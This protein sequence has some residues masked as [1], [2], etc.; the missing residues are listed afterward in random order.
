MTS[1][2]TKNL[3][4]I[5]KPNYIFLLKTICCLERIL[6]RQC[7]VMY[8]T[9]QVAHPMQYKCSMLH[10]CII[11]NV[12]FIIGTRRC[13]IWHVLC[14][15]SPSALYI[16]PEIVEIHSRVIMTLCVVQK[17]DQIGCTHYRCDKFN[18]G[19]I[20]AILKCMCHICL[21]LEKCCWFVWKKGERNNE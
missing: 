4:Q 18:I 14:A 5:H 6:F 7:I 8:F 20:F 12:R 15:V 2:F 13:L 17:R 16:L 9:L 21:G 11:C 3:N 19:K 10:D 1:H